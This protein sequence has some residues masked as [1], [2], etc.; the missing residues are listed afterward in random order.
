[1]THSISL[2]SPVNF[3]QSDRGNFEIVVYISLFMYTAAF[4]LSTVKHR[5]GV[6]V[7]SKCLRMKPAGHFPILLKKNRANVSLMRLP[8]RVVDEK[9]Q[10]FVITENRQK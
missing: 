1:M 9:G 6:A 5:Y 2:N 10:K 8:Y 7:V 4:C 3:F